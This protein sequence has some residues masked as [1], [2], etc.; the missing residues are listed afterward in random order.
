MKVGANS[1]ENIQF[2]PIST[3]SSDLI[4]EEEKKTRKNAIQIKWEDVS[5]NN[6]IYVRQAYTR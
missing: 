2:L 1:K 3:P 6:K 4:T 5:S